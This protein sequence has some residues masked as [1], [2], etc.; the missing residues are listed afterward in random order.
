MWI[1]Q[2]LAIVATPHFAAEH[3][4]DDR[5]DAVEGRAHSC[6]DVEDGSGLE[7][8]VRGEQ[9]G[10]DDVVDEREIAALLRARQRIDTHDLMATGEKAVPRACSR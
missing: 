1:T 7:I 10:A 6:P 5:D 3:T 9:V 4:L 2:S 8:R